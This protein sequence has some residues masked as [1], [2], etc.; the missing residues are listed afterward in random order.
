MRK[1]PRL[2][3][4]AVLLTACRPRP[5]PTPVA[6]PTLDA[7]TAAVSEVVNLVEARAAAGEAFA[8]VA[9][10]YVLRD[11]G[12]VKT[13]DAS[14]ARLDFSDGTILRLAQN[15]SFV[16]QTITPSADGLVARIKLEAGKIW[17]SLTG[18][19]LQVETPVGVAAVRGSFAVI[20]YSPG[21]P[22]NPDD[23]L[24]VL[25]CLEG[26]CTAQND[27]VDAHL[28]NLE[29]V[30]LNR[31]AHLRLTLTGADVEAFLQDNPESQSIIATLTAAPP[32][33]DTPQPTKTPQPSFTPSLVSTG[34]ATR[35]PTET[36][37]ATPAATATPPRLVTATPIVVQ[38]GP[39][40]G[41]HVVRA[42][43]TLFCIGRGYGVL[44][45]AIAQANGLRAPFGLVPD[46][47]L[48]IPA[49][50]WENIPPGAVC[51]PQFT[52]PF[53]GLPVNTASPTPTI[54]L[55]PTPTCVPPDF[56]DPFQ[57]RCRPP[58]TPVP[59]GTTTPVP[60]TL[61]PTPVPPTPTATPDT[62]GPTITNLSVS[63][64]SVGNVTTCNVT[65][66]ADVTDVSGVS[67][68]NVDW[69]ATNTFSVPMPAGSGSVQMTLVS[70][71]T[72]TATWTVTLL[73][74]PFPYY[75][76]VSWSV[77][78]VDGVIVMPNTNNVASLTPIDVF[79][80]DGG[81]P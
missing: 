21:D 42:G 40:I 51:A 48:R 66:M 79:A 28:G 64:S 78:A 12:E 2:F 10:G 27:N 7:H 32:A 70:G 29:R 3:S 16:M 46:Q 71:T 19:T 55:T 52:S 30:V 4:I 39:I 80:T 15:S 8:Q 36:R 63:P 81:C 26:D 45:E 1:L 56:F 25:D 76:N 43:E 50:P 5:T 49:N 60:P 14:K 34:T 69:V 75:G 59:S 73:G 65:F 68:V 23:D 58:D 47:V 41:Q 44:P 22:D 37:T 35:A 31:V 67:L 74:G 61:T 72:Y 20:E 57:Q 18:G 6:A 53:P 62:A 9:L 33:T 11:G 38:T 13:G 54:T 24:L 17:V 77:T